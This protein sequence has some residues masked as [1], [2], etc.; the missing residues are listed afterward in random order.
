M[1]H[2]Y[3]RD[4]RPGRQSSSEG[5]R[6]VGGQVLGKGGR[7]AV[8]VVLSGRI[9][10]LRVPIAAAGSCGCLFKFLLVLGTDK[11]TVNCR[12]TVVAES[13]DSSGQF[14]LFPGELSG[15]FVEFF[16]AG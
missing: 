8:F 7:D 5:G 2:G 10:T 13:D 16:K 14:H 12:L 11:S 3:E 6:F 15:S 9:V 4:I 1:G